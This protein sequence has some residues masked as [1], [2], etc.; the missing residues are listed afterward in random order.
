MKPFDTNGSRTINEFKTQGRAA[1]EHNLFAT[2]A[3]A[4]VVGAGA[5]VR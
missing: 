5:V 3:A 4:S 2:G 1:Q